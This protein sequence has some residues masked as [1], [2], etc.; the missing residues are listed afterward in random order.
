MRLVDI[1]SRFPRFELAR[2]YRVRATLTLEVGTGGLS[3]MWSDAF[4][5]SVF[6]VAERSKSQVKDVTFGNTVRYIVR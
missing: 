3:G 6:P 2:P 4:I 1:R 5:G